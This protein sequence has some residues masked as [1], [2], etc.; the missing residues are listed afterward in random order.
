MQ[1]LVPGAVLDDKVQ[2]ERRLGSGAMGTVWLARHLALDIDVAVKVLKHFDRDAEE[3]ETRF[4]MEARA[5]ARIDSPHVVRVLDH[6][7]HA[8]FP[9]MV[10]ERLVGESMAERLEREGWLEIED[11]VE[12]ICGVAKALDRAHALGVVHR[13]VKPENI[14][15]CADGTVKLIDFGVAKT[16]TLGAP[17][18]TSPGV[19]IG[20]PE[21]MS[22]EQVVSSSGVTA[23]SDLWSLAVV[24]YEAL[25]GDVPFTGESLGLICVAIC[26]GR[27]VPPTQLR[28]GLPEAL[29]AWFASIFAPRASMPF[30]SAAE[31]AQGFRATLLADR[32][33]P[34]DPLTEDP[35]VEDPRVEDPQLPE[36]ES[37]WRAP[38]LV[39]E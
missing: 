21:Y 24:A 38:S 37:P 35:L 22:R 36:V 8:G 18:L 23:A 26:S 3:I 4:A 33:A 14:F 9:Y 10:M 6:G 30:T 29:D 1:S 31:L 2:L 11:V 15:L 5:V 20:T 7:C 34:E 17:G 39:V 25:T 13:D 32:Y 27:H 19:M 12:V 28:K 16:S